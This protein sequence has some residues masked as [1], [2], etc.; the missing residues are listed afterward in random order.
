MGNQ[1]S[2]ALEKIKA[3]APGNPGLGSIQFLELDLAS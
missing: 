1:M 2:D 3:A